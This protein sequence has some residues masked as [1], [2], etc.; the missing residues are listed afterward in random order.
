MPGTSRWAVVG[1]G[2]LGLTLA[3]RLAR[4]GCDVTVLEGAPRLGGLAGAWSLDTV[5]W[6]RHYHVTLLSDSHLRALLAELGLE[7]T[8]EWRQTRAGVYSDGQLHSVSNTVELLRLP[9]LALVDKLRLG[10]TI[11]YGSKVRDWRRLERVPVERWLRRWSGNR[12]FERLWL[13]LL[14]A[15]L[16]ESYRE[17]CA[18]FMWAT[19]QRLYAA[20]RGGLKKEMFGYVPGGYARILERF[21][22]VL[23]AEGVRLELGCRVSQIASTGGDVEVTVPD[24]GSMRFDHVVV[25]ASPSVAARLIDGLCARERAR[26]E[27][28]RY[29]GV[30]CAS[31]LLERPLSPYYL[32]Y[33]T[34]ETPLTAV[35]EMS[36]FVDRS[37][38]AGRSL[39]YLPKYCPADDPLMNASDDE[40]EDLFL[41]S[42]ERMYPEF[43][44]DDV[45]CFRVSRVRE[46]FAIPTLSYSQGVPG[47]DCT[48]PGVHVVNS[49]QIINGTLNVNETVQLAERAVRSLLE[50]VGTPVRPAPAPRPPPRPTPVDGPGGRV[51]RKPLA[52]LSLDLDDVWSYMKTHGDPGW[53]DLPS[54]LDVVVPRALGFLR[55][56][57]LTITWFVVGQDAALERNR[58]LLA[59]I[60]EAG[61]EIGNH[62]FLHEPWLHLYSREAIEEELARA[63]T[64][65]E[66]ATGR[67]PDGFRGPGFSLSHDV[68]AV[69]G[70]RGFRYD[71]STLPTYTGPLSGLF[72]SR[73]MREMDPEDRARRKGAYGSFR[74]GT[75]PLKPYRWRA[76]GSSLLELPVTTMPI[77]R[78]P[79]HM[80]YLLY[81][82]QLSPRL[83]RA[84]F[85]S[86]LRLCR[87]TGVAPSILLHSHDFAGSDDVEQ[88]SHFPGMSL[89]SDVKVRRMAELLDQLSRSFQVVPMGRLA[90]DVAS[91][92]GLRLIQPRFFHRGRNG[93]AGPGS[94]GGQRSALP[95]G[96]P[97]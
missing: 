50:G 86:A 89:P 35:V 66:E 87:I 38:F 32:T 59:S 71:A 1:G 13:P 68:L 52:G 18:A 72:F 45:A 61:H 97:P 24:G 5:V 25:T 84:Y 10:L 26:L 27:A 46:V 8:M 44:R 3:H 79:I 47:F 21:A 58:S 9:G 54:Y 95:V 55:Q 57:H 70:E 67:R 92:E 60:A 82:S 73:T 85:G 23:A 7:D 83:A 80:T 39:V 31:L 77:L 88:L 30:V 90:D 41:A 22:E 20:R 74:D 53:E 62:S 6:D 37:Q 56:R 11:F 91:S 12:T 63:D 96:G 64:A 15:K 51:A 2:M 4:H 69:L 65:I 42:L 16:G 43:H 33:I 78:T 34:D 49:S 48:V 94:A 81:M 19:I 36:A 93:R 17:S 29:Q 75:R 28:L 76:D 40:V 14:R